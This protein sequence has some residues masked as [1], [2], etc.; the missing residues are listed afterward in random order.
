MI[1]LAAALFLS[2]KAWAL[3]EIKAGGIPLVYQHCG[4]PPLSTVSVF[5]PS[6]RGAEVE[7]KKGAAALAQAALYAGLPWRGEGRSGI[8]TDCAVTDD[9]LEFF[10]QCPTYRLPEALDGLARALS[11]MPTN[12][13]AFKV[14]KAGLS[15]SLYPSDDILQYASQ[16]L[17]DSTYLDA[18][19]D[20]L[21]AS[22]RAL[23]NISREDAEDFYKKHITVENMI[24]SAVT[25]MDSG[26]LAA[27]LEKT[28]TG[29]LPSGGSGYD[30]PPAPS[31]APEE[32]LQAER[33]DMAGGIFV[34]AL[35]G[36]HYRTRE[37]F[38]LEL[39]AEMLLFE[40]GESMVYAHITRNAGSNMLLYYAKIS[41]DNYAGDREFIE[42]RIYDAYLRLKDGQY[43]EGV[44]ASLKGRYAMRLSEPENYALD[45][46]VSFIAGAAK[47][48]ELAALIDSISYDELRE[49]SLKYIKPE[50][51]RVLV[52]RGANK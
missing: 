51:K 7:S 48:G 18:S 13:I 8:F 34:V 25:D 28:F 45:A 3:D 49:A 27:L 29:A 16:I 1:F 39:V 50:K 43:L 46:G 23:E 2:G 21:P 24:V 10:L 38:C 37:Y 22:I 9:Y 40:K 41:P 14:L 44:K 12:E 6:G 36:P 52:I 32:E 33:K 20:T 30:I 31:E 19:A 15:S 47:P 5:F 11:S 42:K 35:A 4:E 26:S 17:S